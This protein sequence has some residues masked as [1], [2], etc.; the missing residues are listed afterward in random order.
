MNKNDNLFYNKDI[1][2]LFTNTFDNI[3]LKVKN[4]ESKEGNYDWKNMK[5]YFTKLVVLLVNFD[6]N[7]KNRDE[8]IKCYIFTKISFIYYINYL[9]YID[10]D[11]ALNDDIDTFNNEFKY[12]L[13]IIHNIHLSCKYPLK[14]LNILHPFF[15]NAKSYYNRD[16]ETYLNICK[17]NKKYENICLQ[18]TGSCY[19]DNQKSKLIS[20]ITF[21]H[22]MVKNLDYNNY[23][24]FYYKNMIDRKHYFN[25][26]FIDFTNFVD[27]IPSY[28]KIL[29][30]DVG[31]CN[32]KE[33]VKHVRISEIIKF[34]LKYFPYLSYTKN[35]GRYVISH[36]KNG[37][38]IV[39]EKSTESINIIFQYNLKYDLLQTVVE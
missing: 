38:K 13:K 29:S 17:T 3:D 32:N 14:L 24:D 5:K 37:G 27:N 9:E 15:K 12:N 31:D 6:L 11:D 21:N 36:I 22:N 16:D 19:D 30:I 4:C 1:I 10:H 8:Y 39:I 35:D 26:N 28:K 18:I 33:S 7:K 20:L 34:I 23:S 2:N 25:N